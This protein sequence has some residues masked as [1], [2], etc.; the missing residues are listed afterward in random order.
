MKSRCKVV[1][2]TGGIGSGK[3]TV[4]EIFRSLRVPVYLA[5][6]AG[7][8]LTHEDPA[9]KKSIAREFGSDMY[10]GD[11]NLNSKDLA[12]IVFGDKAQ[13]DKLNSI[14]HPA[15]QRDFEDWLSRQDA[16][17]VIKEA[18]ILIETGSYRDADKLIVVTAPEK[19]R[20]SRVIERDDSDEKSV[21]SR[22]ANQMPQD[23]K[24]RYADFLV[25]NEDGHPLIPQVTKIHSQLSNS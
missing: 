14:I 5:D 10:D 17:Y 21:R 7:R 3:S 9:V 20:I 22:M 18:A 8:K 16:P 6:E 24:D 1:G 25:R 23:E 12:A 19:L 2:L 11:G 4:A 13:L 15:V